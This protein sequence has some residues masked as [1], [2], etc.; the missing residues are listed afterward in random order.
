MPTVK[1]RAWPTTAEGLLQMGQ[2]RMER[3][4][5]VNKIHIPSV[6]VCEEWNWGACAFYRPQGIQIHLPSCGRP[7]TEFQTRNWTWP[8]STTDREPYGVI[9]HELGHHCDWTASDRQGSYFGDYSVNTR[10]ESREAQLTSYCPNDCEWF[11]E[12][13]RL[14]VTNQALLKLLR[15]K[16]WESLSIRW[17]PVSSEDWREELGPIVPSRIVANLE[18]KIEA[19]RVH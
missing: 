3:F 11:A 8:G 1:P 4:C 19:A 9:C 2:Y 14:F 6:T 16:T 7:C 13:F 5:K 17:I 10:K 15:P 12:M 18:K